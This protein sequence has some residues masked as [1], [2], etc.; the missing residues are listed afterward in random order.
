VLLC[1]FPASAY[2][3]ST[4]SGTGVC[5]WWPTHAHSFQIDAQGT[6]DA[7]GTAVFD[8]IRNSF[9]TWAAVSCSDLSF[10]EEPLSTAA[11]DRVIGYFSGATNH[12]LVL[13]RTQSCRDVVPAADTC[14][15]L[16][17][18][19]NKYDCWEQGDGIIATT[20]TTSDRVTGRILDTDIELND[21]RARDG[22]KL[23]F[24]AVDG[25]PCTS[26]DKTGCVSIDVQNTVTH[27]SGHTLGLDH[28]TD[29]NA[30]MYA[31]APE[32]QTSKRILGADD[33][34]GVCAIYPRG[35]PTVTCVADSTVTEDPSG[36]G[37]SQTE[38]GPGAAL[39]A[40]ALLL[41]IRRR[42]RSRP[43]L[44]ISAS[45]SPARSSR[46]RAR[47]GAKR[48]RS[49]SPLVVHGV[50]GPQHA[51]A[52]GEPV[53]PVVGEVDRQERDRPGQMEPSLKVTKRC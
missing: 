19:G 27:E 11:S 50:H 39:A 4:V 9:Q 52:V 53:P 42:S 37:C 21:A 18:C 47:P 45:T 7:P 31:S 12:N 34:Q 44:P 5:L 35:A 17:G 3:R 13:F 16:G 36:C 25:L 38:T 32:G 49:C 6:P 29:P 43:Q 10:P 22:T 23:T 41:Q 8:A 24:T 40:L 14:L 20:T 15:R 28:T 2:T 48:R 51:D 26:S 46:P 30:T 33:I 1:G